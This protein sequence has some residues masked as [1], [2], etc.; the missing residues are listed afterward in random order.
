[1]Y[2]CPQIK[3]AQK[4]VLI[5]SVIPNTSYVFV[6]NN[7]DYCNGISYIEPRFLTNIKIQK[8]RCPVYSNFQHE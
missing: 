1:M 7:I 6:I 2:F 8:I 5:K 3:I 4:N